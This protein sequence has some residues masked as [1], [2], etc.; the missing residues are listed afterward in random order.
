MIDQFLV[1]MGHE[2][3]GV[4]FEVGKGL[5]VYAIDN[6]KDA[7]NPALDFGTKEV[8]TDVEELADY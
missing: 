5:E 8:V 2:I 6:N 4:I 7:R 1:I 3:A